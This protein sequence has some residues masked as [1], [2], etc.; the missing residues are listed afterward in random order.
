MK[1]LKHIWFITVKDLKLFLTDR[2]A[3][4][5]FILFPFMFIVLFNFLLRGVGGQDSRLELHLI[6]QEP[7]GGLSHQIIGAL[8]TKDEAQLKPGEPKIVWDKDYNEARQTVEDKKL[9][10]FLAFPADF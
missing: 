10:G 5:F 1:Q 9:A 4:F 8:E 7:A 6:T 2:L 3:L